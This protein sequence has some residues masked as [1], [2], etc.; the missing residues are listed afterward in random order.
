MD[1]FPFPGKESALR[2][3]E[4]DPC[5]GKIPRDEIPGLFG[6]A[7]ERGAGAAKEV[8]AVC[9]KC[10]P[11]FEPMIKGAGLTVER[12]DADYV[13]GPTRYFSDYLPGRKL[14]NLYTGSV[15]LW[16]AENHLS[17]PQAENMILAHEFYH[18]LEWNKIGLTS[19]LRLVP[20]F[21]LGRLKI[22]KTGIRALSEIG[23]HAF[24]STCFERSEA[25]GKGGTSP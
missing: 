9:A 8:L 21:E 25:N 7:W 6:A 12:V 5:C 10:P 3:F 22:G 1:S 17:V 16:A 2:E 14:V 4:R 11:D 23:A 15:S 20:A 18:Y 13:A 19:R 24:V